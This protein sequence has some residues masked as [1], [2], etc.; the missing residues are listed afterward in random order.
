ME[1]A[2]IPLSQDKEA[3]VDVS[4]A[5]K[6]T[7]F[8]WTA[9]RV[10]RRVYAVR[11]ARDINGK[12]I[13]LLM[14]RVIT[15]APAGLDVDH[16]NGNGLDNRRCNLRLATRSENLRNQRCKRPGSTSRYKGV[17]ASG[18]RWGAS[19]AL[20][21]K[22]HWLGSFDSEEEA[23]RAYDKAAV[24]HFGEFA[25]TNADLFGEEQVPA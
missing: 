14:H 13:K 4:D 18:A 19:L 7:P 12:W 21:G 17:S 25:C 22:R 11:Q 23:A 9:Q 1:I 10:G 24:D 2:R 6:V 16:I 5:A 8:K 20:D 15:N 3:V